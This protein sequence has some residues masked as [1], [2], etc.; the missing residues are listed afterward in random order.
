MEMLIEAGAR[1]IS[2]NY[3]E[4]SKMLLSIHFTMNVKGGF[5]NFLIQPNIFGIHEKL[6]EQCKQPS[7][8]TISHAN[9]VAWR[10]HRD[11]LDAQLAVIESDLEPAN[12]VFFNN[13]IN[14]KGE[15]IFQ[16]FENLKLLK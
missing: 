15:S 4:G 9:A 1:N 2:T 12:K 5:Y 6:K 10:I 7:H 8:K 13:L 14:D 16:K 11:L 3:E